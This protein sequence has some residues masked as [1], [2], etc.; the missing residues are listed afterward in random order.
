MIVRC[1]LALSRHRAFSASR[2]ALLP[3]LLHLLVPLDGWVDET[4]LG[5][6]RGWLLRLVKG[7]EVEGGAVPMLEGLG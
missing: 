4:D 1:V 7:E 3:L 2:A 6:G 5:L